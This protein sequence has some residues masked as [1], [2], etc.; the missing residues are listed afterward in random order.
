MKRIIQWGP[1]PLWRTQN[2][3]RHSFI[4]ATGVRSIFYGRMKGERLSNCVSRE[5]RQGQ[6][7]ADALLINDRRVVPNSVAV[8]SAEAA[9]VQSTSSSGVPC[10]TDCSKCRVAQPT[11][12]DN[13]I[14]RLVA[15]V[16]RT[17]LGYSGVSNQPVELEIRLR[18]GPPASTT[19]AAA[20]VV[21]D[22]QRNIAPL[23]PSSSST[24]KNVSINTPR[25]S[26][27]TRPRFPPPSRPIKDYGRLLR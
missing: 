19:V 12:R 7:A 6:P 17:F 27:T 9:S 3:K 23:P 22:E 21:G 4:I 14:G 26:V 10:S 15:N 11:T 13:L 8:F 16:T 1:R 2:K 24:Q 25:F 20:D 18:V 5:W